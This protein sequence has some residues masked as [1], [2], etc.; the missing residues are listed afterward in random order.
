MTPPPAA[1]DRFNQTPQPLKATQRTRKGQSHSGL[2]FSL[3]TVGTPSGKTP[4]K[5][6]QF[7]HFAEYF[8]PM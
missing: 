6:P 5:A 8:V 7:A 4:S 2:A 1:H 3:S